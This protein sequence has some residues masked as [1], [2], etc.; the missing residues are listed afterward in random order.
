[1]L[2]GQ[3]QRQFEWWTGVAADAHVMRDAALAALAAHSS[4]AAVPSRAV[5]I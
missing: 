5:Q 4:A 2:V 1:M 3:A